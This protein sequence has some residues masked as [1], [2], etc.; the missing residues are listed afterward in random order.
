[1]SDGKF[2][3]SLRAAHS[4]RRQALL[5]ACAILASGVVAGCARHHPRYA[6][7]PEEFR[8]GFDKAT[9][10]VLKKVDATDDQK[11]RIKP[12]ADDLA[13][14]LSGFREEHK[15][16]RSR[17]VKALE[18]DKVDPAEVEKIRADALALA[19]KA[20][21]KMAEAIVKASD[22]LSPAQRRQLTDRWKKCM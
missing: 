21:A 10:R 19:D 5:I 16:L 14:A 13:M 7:T 8:E 1:M 3:D 20:T 2:P 9:Q 15:A 17:F 6:K 22:I 4:F 12:I 11:A 18:A